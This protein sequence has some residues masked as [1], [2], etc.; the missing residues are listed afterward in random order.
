MLRELKRPSCG[1]TQPTPDA[2]LDKTA[3]VPQCGGTFSVARILEEFGGP[4]ISA[5]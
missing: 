4:I 1:Y 5:A 3:L 2:V